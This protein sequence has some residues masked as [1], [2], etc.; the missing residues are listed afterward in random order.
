MIVIRHWQSA[1][2]FVRSKG[3]STQRAGSGSSSFEF[4]CVAVSVYET[5]AVLSVLRMS[6]SFTH[7]SRIVLL[8]LPSSS[9]VFA[10]EQHSIKS[11]TSKH[12]L[13]LL[14]PYL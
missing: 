2:R 5:M 14:R 3:N 8:A 6:H 9:Y 1:T 12:L 11:T 7:T 4:E 10:R 13:A